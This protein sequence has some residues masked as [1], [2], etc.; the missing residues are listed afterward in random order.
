MKH[1]RIKQLL[2][3][4]IVIGREASSMAR[5][6]EDA[7]RIDQPLVVIDLDFDGRAQDRKSNLSFA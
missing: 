5:A 3:S 6:Y 1:S 4:L 2:K 7:N